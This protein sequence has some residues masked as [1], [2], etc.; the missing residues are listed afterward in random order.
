M[1]GDA[2]ERLILHAPMAGWMGDLSEVPDPVFAERMMG[3]GVAIDPTEGRLVAPCDGVI[4]LVPTTAHSVTMRSPEGVEILMHVGLE[5]VAL[6]GAGFT[7]H[8]ANGDAVRRG[9]PLLSFDM[10]L[11]LARAKSLLTP[12]ILT[13]GDD[14][15]FEAY[16][17][18]RLLAPNDVIGEVRLLRSVATPSPGD[19]DEHRAEFVLRLPHGLHARPAARVAGRAKA[20]AADVVVH[21]H[22]GRANAR[23]PVALMTLGA[24]FGDTIAVSARGG[25]AAEAIAAITDLMTRDLEGAEQDTTSHRPARVAAALDAA[26]AADE[27]LRGVCAV[28]GLAIGPAVS[29]HAR[30]RDVAP[31]GAGAAAE[32]DAL[33]AALASI[34]RNLERSA[35]GGDRT[36]AG[37]AEAH[38]ALLE[39]VDLLAAAEGRVAAGRS[40]GFAWRETL[41]GYSGDLRATGNP[42]L[43]ERADDLLDLERR[44]LA[45]LVGDAG[46]TV[47]SFSD[48]AILLADDLLP[49]QLMEIDLGRLGGVCTA[50]GGPTS[51]AAIMAAAAGVPMLVAVGPGVMRI[52]DGAPVLLDATSGRLVPDPA[53]D[54]RQAAERIIVAAAAHRRTAHAAAAEDCRTLDG[55]RIELFANLGSLDD[56]AH[57]VAQ[58]AEGC[59]LLRTEFLFADRHSAPDEAEQR[60]AY[61]AIAD[62]LGGRS[63]IVRTLDIGGDKP[64]PYL[65]LPPEDN[66]ALGLRG[67]RTSLWRP[68]LLDA[69]LAAVLG[70]RPAGRCRIMLPMVASPHEIRAVRARLDAI[71]ADRGLTHHIP[72]GIMIETP[73]AAITADRLAAEADFFSIGT[74]DLTQY[75]LA[76]DRTN[77]LV[78]GQVDSFHP[79]VLRLIAAAARGA[80]AHGRPVGT[81][82]G[83]ASD[84]A[85]ALLLIGLGVTELSA[86]PA[87]IP[88]IKA[89]VR[90]VTLDECR[91][92]AMR[93]LDADG[94][95][96][97]RALVRD[98][99]ASSNTQGAA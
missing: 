10:D 59:G 89:H 72:L 28:P 44:V 6:A 41:R 8:V 49:S 24:A 92:L 78:A 37:V 84:P 73:A 95:D 76:M 14:F 34:A 77:P 33:A 62:A 54:A 40:A 26:A 5:T 60:G 98:H 71:A 11:V 45:A 93:A 23:S 97:V 16:A 12:L 65:P 13:N 1:S 58:G 42:L 7:A 64:V 27:V 63:L 3:D 15:A 46:D 20:F 29:I 32:R 9:D 22:G 61:Q 70:V 68:E 56:A 36:Q 35:A 69:Q 67:V 18:G 87:L 75:A 38:L 51:H 94:P 55:V 66:P 52:A 43:A 39:D 99:L 31:A 57:A 19:G 48:G 17:P 74:N 25:D 86:T 30:D 85:G 90:R 80:A 53:D 2:Q 4:V 47:V 96:A 82:G 50:G 83:L 88:E 91:A 21:A 79:A 81:C